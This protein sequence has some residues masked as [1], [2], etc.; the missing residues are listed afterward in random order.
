MLTL[1]RTLNPS[2]GGN[3]EFLFH[4]CVGVIAEACATSL[5]VVRRLQVSVLC[6]CSSEC[7]EGEGD[8][9]KESKVSV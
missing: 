2:L 4:C 1:R 8:R 5:G 7:G 6:A 3:K 9:E